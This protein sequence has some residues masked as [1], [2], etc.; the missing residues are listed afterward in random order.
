MDSENQTTPEPTNPGVML[1][2]HL[3]EGDLLQ[4]PVPEEGIP[5]FLPDWYQGELPVLVYPRLQDQGVQQ[6]DNVNLEVTPYHIYYGALRE[7][8]ETA[9]EERAAVLKQLTQGWNANAGLEVRQMA[10]KHIERALLHCELAQELEPDAEGVDE[11]AEIVQQ[12]LEYLPDADAPGGVGEPTGEQADFQEAQRI[13]NEDPHQAIALVQPLADA[14]PD[15]GEL[16]FIL[17]AAHRRAGDYEEA[18]RCLRRSGRLAP[19]EPFVW[20]ELALTSLEAG[21]PKDA[22]DAIQKALDVDP[23]NPLYLID[24]GKARLALGDTDGAEEPIRRAQE[25]VPDD[26]EVQAAVEALEAAG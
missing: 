17:G 26:P 6:G 9:D 4:L 20:R 3:F 5:G 11:A 7:L 2:E 15:S 21:R 23:E 1:R 12:A 19:Q 10:R 25:L 18:E 24:L 8:A 13:M 14:Y 22:E 16:W